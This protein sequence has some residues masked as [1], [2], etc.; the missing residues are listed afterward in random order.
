MTG[1]VYVTVRGDALYCNNSMNDGRSVS[2]SEGRTLYCNNGMNDGRSVSYSEERTLYRNNSANE[3]HTK[4]MYKDYFFLLITRKEF[5]NCPFNSFHLLLDYWLYQLYI[6][7]WIWINYKFIVMCSWLVHSLFKYSS[8][9]YHN[10]KKQNW[11]ND[12]N[13]ACVVMVMPCMQAIQICMSSS[14]NVVPYQDAHW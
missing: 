11:C 5:I 7:I 2:Y 10:N 13:L 3:K 12:L 1:A 8:C 6:C 14:T 9:F 4:Q